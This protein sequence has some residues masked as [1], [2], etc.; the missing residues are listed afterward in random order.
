M[1]GELCERSSLTCLS[2]QTPPLRHSA[3]ARGELLST[4]RP[5]TQFFPVTFSPLDC[6]SSYARL[7]NTLSFIPLSQLTQQSNSRRSCLQLDYLTQD[8][9]Y[10]RNHEYVGGVRLRSYA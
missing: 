9:I 3:G 4:Q 1:V 5:L 8:S 2:L 7:Q 10:A 6:Y